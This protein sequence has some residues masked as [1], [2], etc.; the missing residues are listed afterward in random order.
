MSHVV[1]LDSGPLG[2][3]TNPRLSTQSVACAR[4]LQQL[5]VHGW[6]V[7]VS[8]IADYEVRRELLRAGKSEG[9]KRLDALSK[10]LEYLP[11]STDAMRCGRRRC[12]GQ[13]PDRRDNPPLMTRHSTVTSSWLRKP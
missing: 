2:L 7:I 1:L 10:Q 13:R 8:E 9:L 11:L 5:V 4:W 3:V 6:R 12:F